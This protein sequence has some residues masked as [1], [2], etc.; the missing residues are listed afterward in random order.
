MS[1]HRDQADNLSQHSSVSSTPTENTPLIHKEEQGSTWS[2]EFYWLL[3]NALPIVFT[4]LMQNSLQMAS[5]FTLGHLVS[6]FCN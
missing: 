3:K 1:R 4:F 2:T 5:I 6:L